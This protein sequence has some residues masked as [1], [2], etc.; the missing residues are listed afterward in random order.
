MTTPE[1]SLGEATL[2]SPGT[3]QVQWGWAPPQS[4]GGT[5]RVN[6]F[7][8]VENRDTMGT[9]TFTKPVGY[10]AVRIEHWFKV[11]SPGIPA[12][13]K[14][15][16]QIVIT[17]FENDGPPHEFLGRAFLLDSTNIDHRTFRRLATTFRHLDDSASRTYTLYVVRKNASKHT[18]MA[19]GIELWSL[20]HAFSFKPE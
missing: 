15:E 16:L 7:D 1:I 17:E 18:P 20:L 6:V 14:I 3:Q 10:G 9:G 11:S 13:E 12:G 8:F 2:R 5:Q 4:P 19:K